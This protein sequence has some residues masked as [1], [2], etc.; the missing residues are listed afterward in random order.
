MKKTHTRA[1]AR[2]FVAGN[3]LPFFLF[4]T[5]RTAFVDSTTTVVSQKEG[6]VFRNDKCRPSRQGVALKHAG[7]SK[8]Q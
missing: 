8:L 6:V 5:T 3:F 2:D 1:R 4:T 7:A